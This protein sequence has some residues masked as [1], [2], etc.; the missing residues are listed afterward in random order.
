MKRLLVLLTY[1]LIHWLQ[2]AGAVAQATSA[3]DF[4]QW[5]HPQ[6]AAASPD[7]IYLTPTEREVLRLCNLARMN[8][9]LFAQTYLAEYGPEADNFWARTL[10]HKLEENKAMPPLGSQMGLCK[11]AT[12]LAYHM[13]STGDTK[14]EGTEGGVFYDRIHRYFPGAR[15]FATNFVAGSNEA[16]EI[17]LAML[18][19]EGDSSFSNRNNI[20]SE[21][22]DVV[23]ISVRPH[24]LLCAN[25]VM[26]FAKA[27]EQN[28]TSFR[29]MPM[30]YRMPKHRV[31][32]DEDCPKGAKVRIR[33]P[34]RYG[35][36][37]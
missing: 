25:A 7:A 11:S 1:V 20:L 32:V 27:P 28:Q 19:S 5:Q 2:P 13:G 4:S 21:D 22:I 9:P 8:G 6:Y 31:N 33:K 16:V 34:K 23:G 35:P 14:Y 17:A 18:L 29:P 30:N 26:D 12:M 36:I 10:R 24:K 15:T 3:A 37:N